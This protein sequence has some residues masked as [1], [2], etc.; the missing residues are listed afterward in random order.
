MLSP[1]DYSPKQ[2]VKDLVARAKILFIVGA[3][4]TGKNTIIQHLSKDPR[5]YEIITATTRP[6][7]YNHGIKEVDGDVYYF[8]SID[9]FEQMIKNKEL[10]EYALVHNQNYYGTPV[11]EFEKSVKENRIAIADIE[12]QG[13]KSF[14]KLNKELKTIFLL[15]PSLDALLS[16]IEKRD[17][18]Y[19]DKENI[20]ERLISSL[21]EY[22]AALENN[23]Y[24]YVINDN[25]NDALNEINEILD[26]KI[27]D[28]NPKI[29]LIKNLKKQIEEH[30]L[31]L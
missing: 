23:N 6:P 27:P 25:V 11:S 5:F 28:Q 3:S 20:K 8:V 4:G 16:R 24:I 26:R 2:A 17:H 30:L 1:Q 10:V 21:E 22:S 13:V 7:R 29:E 19:S 9:K 18:N 31:A 15:P 14:L 12:V